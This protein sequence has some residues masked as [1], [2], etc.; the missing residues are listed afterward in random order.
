MNF[1]APLSRQ[2]KPGALVV[3]FAGIPGALVVVPTG[4]IGALLG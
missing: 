4:A 1:R 3:V 2:G